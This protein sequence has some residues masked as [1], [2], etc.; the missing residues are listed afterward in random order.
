M[1]LSDA[2]NTSSVRALSLKH[3]DAQLV[4]HSCAITPSDPLDTAR[5]H[6]GPLNCQ[7]RRS[8][9]MHPPSGCSSR[10]CG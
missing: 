8:T 10:P 6:S 9:R 4:I 5:P 2:N 7:N 3:V 1:Y